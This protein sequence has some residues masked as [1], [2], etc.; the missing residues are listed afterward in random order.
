M[1]GK[2]DLKPLPL[3]EEDSKQIFTVSLHCV[4]SVKVVPLTFFPQGGMTVCI[5]T[6]TSIC[7][8]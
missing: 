8:V 3:W 2:A 5:P 7:F 6:E 1:N 4:R